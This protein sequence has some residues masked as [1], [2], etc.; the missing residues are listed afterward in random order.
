M[1]SIPSCRPRSL[2]SRVI[3]RRQISSHGIQVAFA[4]VST[5][6]GAL[7]DKW[8]SSD[9]LLTIVHPQSPPAFTGSLDI[10]PLGEIRLVASHL[11][12]LYQA[13]FTSGSSPRGDFQGLLTARLVEVCSHTTE[14]LDIAS[15][16]GMHSQ[17]Q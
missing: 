12:S 6:F 15:H 8:D 13:V 5:Q 14:F 4:P 9:R 1:S 3:T 7:T 11:F 16:L 17:E 2:H 10:F